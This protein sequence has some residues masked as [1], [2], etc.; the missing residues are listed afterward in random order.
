[1]DGNT[2]SLKVQLWRN[3]MNSEDLLCAQERRRKKWNDYYSC[4]SYLFL[5]I[6]IW[7]CENET[8]T[9]IMELFVFIL[10]VMMLKVICIWSKVHIQETPLKLKSNFHKFEWA[11][12][13]YCIVKS[14][15]HCL[16]GLFVSEKKDIIDGLVGNFQNTE[17]TSI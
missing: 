1:M 10:V 9:N 8:K 17:A 16:N 7:K 14:S 2:A 13:Y 15:Q 3:E 11:L 12:L 5:R 4:R 6:V